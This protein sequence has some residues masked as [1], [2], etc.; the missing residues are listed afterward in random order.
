M[1]QKNIL[2][3]ITGSIAAYKMLD[4]IR[5]LKE[6]D[7]G[8]TA[9][10]TKA[11]EQFVTPLS[12]ASLSGNKVYTDMF[13]LTDEV[14]MGHIELSRQ[15]DLVVVS[16]ASAGILACMAQGFANDLASTLLL[17]TDKNVLVAPAMN[18]HMWEHKA[19]Q[20]NVEQLKADGILFADPEE[21]KMACGETGYGRLIEG[22]ALVEAIEKA[23]HG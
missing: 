22:N 20:R 8:V 21:G 18:V 4:I 17:A 23:L 11:A 1:P 5:A 6:K 12:V 3:I 9:V 10:L 13:S 7:I 19:V 16:P 15:A 2:L 14:E